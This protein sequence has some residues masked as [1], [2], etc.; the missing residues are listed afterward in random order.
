M[1][2]S[3]ISNLRY[4]PSLLEVVR[5][6]DKLVYINQACQHLIRAFIFEM[7][8]DDCEYSPFKIVSDGLGHWDIG[9]FL[10]FVQ[11]CEFFS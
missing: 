1:K 4:S 6:F 2:Y 3:E 8:P 11:C 10:K 7:Y 5:Q 9:K